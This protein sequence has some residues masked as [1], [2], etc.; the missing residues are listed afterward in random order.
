M[1]FILGDLLHTWRSSSY[2]ERRTTDYARSV[3]DDIALATW[4]LDHGADPNAACAWD[5]TPT[6]AAMSRA[7]LAT[8]A[9][10]F[11][12]GADIGRGQLL[13]NAVYRDGEDEA[14]KLV[15][16]LLEKGA[17][18]DEIQYESQPQ[19]FRELEAFSLGTPLHYA[20]EQG[21]EGLVACLL[22]RGADWR[23]RDTRGRTAR[24][25][26]E[27]LKQAGVVRMLAR[28]KCV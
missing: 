12:R 21:R 9:L 7:S 22:G 10:L 13:H 5:F 15:A 4:F 18:I 27:H 23:V 26:A 20:A 17:G 8:I 1:F 3:S 25:A 24:Q 6:S 28:L 2:L 16:L 11:A 19:T 14:V